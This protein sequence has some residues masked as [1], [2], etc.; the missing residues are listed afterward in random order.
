M[1]P[2]ITALLRQK[3]ARHR[4]SVFLDG[5]FAFGLYEETVLLHALKKGVDLSG[6]LL[7]AVHHD[8]RRIH[9]RFV[10]ER[11]LATRMRSEGELRKR[12]QREEL[13]DDIIDDTIT[14]F[15]RVQLIDDAAYAAAWIRDRR[16]LKPRSTVLLRRELRARGIAEELIE[17]SL[18]EEEQD[19]SSLALEL[20]R[21]WLERHASLA[22]DKA[23]RRLMGFLQRR[24]FSVSVAYEVVRR[25]FG[26]N[27]V[28]D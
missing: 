1:M 3:K 23:L 16:R 21:N 14:T 13:P 7:D 22:R 20:A 18:R 19:D 12:L 28:A 5:E 6:P 27:A 25:L 11:F 24:G 15:R 26:E 8:D 9:A 17:Q 4:V 2:R 10:G